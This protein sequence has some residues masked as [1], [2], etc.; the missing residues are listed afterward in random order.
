MS[1]FGLTKEWIVT[2]FL[3]AFGGE[4]IEDVDPASIVFEGIKGVL[5][6]HDVRLKRSAL[7]TLQLPIAVT[8]GSTIKLLR[9]TFPIIKDFYLKEQAVMVQVCARARAWCHM[10]CTPPPDAS[11]PFSHCCDE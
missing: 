2:K 6:M 7:D 8:E 10:P 3:K 5:T 9:I 11:I 4:Y 1:I